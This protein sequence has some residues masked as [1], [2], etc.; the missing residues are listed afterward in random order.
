MVREQV[1][2]DG[3]HEYGST[4]YGVMYEGKEQP[5]QAQEGEGK[6]GGGETERET[7]GNRKKRTTRRPGEH[8]NTREKKRRKL[9]TRGN[10]QARKDW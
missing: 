1:S 6:E 7:E 4:T 2:K 9:E 10:L 3:R 8:T 5:V